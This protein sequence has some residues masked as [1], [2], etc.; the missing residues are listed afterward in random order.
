MGETRFDLTGFDG[1]AKNTSSSKFDL[2]GFDEDL[3]KKDVEE[4]TESSTESTT[5]SEASDSEAQST[6]TEI[7][8]GIKGY[9]DNNA[10]Y[11]V[12]DG[13]WKIKRNGEWSSFPETSHLHHRLD[14]AYPEARTTQ[15][16]IQDDSDKDAKEPG[17][18]GEIGI[19]MENTADKF[20][21]FKGEAFKTVLG[22]D[23][24]SL[25]VA[26]GNKAKDKLIKRKQE[27][28]WAKEDS[29][30]RNFKIQKSIIKD[31]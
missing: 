25:D 29:E 26:A 16:L 5:T 28:A 17:F 8:T 14:E 10:Q 19:W 22:D 15:D 30:I 1:E 24:L 2:T 9:S 27:E 4:S 18:F 7:Y 23:V 11:T 21:I 13:E 31:L 12:Q 6:E 20:A 3:K